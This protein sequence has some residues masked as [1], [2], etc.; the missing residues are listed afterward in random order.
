V[1]EFLQALER[2]GLPFF[3]LG[4]AEGA[5]IFLSE[6]PTP[7]YLS[8]VFGLVEAHG[9]KLTEAGPRSLRRRQIPQWID[10]VC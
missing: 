4:D 3:S 9:L 8:Q 5:T 2:A 7:T 1:N 6:Q 10:V